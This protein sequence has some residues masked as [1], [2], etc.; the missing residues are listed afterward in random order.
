MQDA[1][2]GLGSVEM[3][4]FSGV[5]HEL[6]ADTGMTVVLV[7]DQVG[8]EGDPETGRDGAAT[9]AATTPEATDPGPGEPVVVEDADM[10]D[11]SETASTDRS[12]VEPEPAVVGAPDAEA[13]ERIPAVEGVGRSPGALRDE[14]AQLSTE[15][16][17]A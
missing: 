4:W 3:S 5:C 12:G 9:V 1:D 16:E 17:R 11:P 10:S 2:A 6:V 8:Q 14:P 15:G 13:T 7:G